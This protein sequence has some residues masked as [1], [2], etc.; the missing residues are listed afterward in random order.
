MTVGSEVE[1]KLDL[2]LRKL[3]HIEKLLALGEEV[4]EE[5]ELDAITAY[6]E[7]RRSGK[8]DLVPWKAVLN[9]L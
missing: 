3:E 5:D 2:V 8:V 1:K 4:P 9:D 6:L 7:R